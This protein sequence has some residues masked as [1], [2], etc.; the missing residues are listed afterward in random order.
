MALA[1]DIKPEINVPTAVAIL[2]KD[3]MCKPR[4]L[5]AAHSDLRQWTV[6]PSG[7]H[8]GAAEEPKLMTED[9]RSF[10]RPLRRG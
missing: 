6:F 10:V 5:V 2:P 1:N 4:S 7:G 8:F 3:L 9:I